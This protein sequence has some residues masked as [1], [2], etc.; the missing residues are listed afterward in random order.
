MDSETCGCNQND[1][2][3]DEK[4]D[5]KLEAMSIYQKRNSSLTSLSLPGSVT[6][7]EW[8]RCK[9]EDSCWLPHTAPTDQGR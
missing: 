4:F 9:K 6:E 7:S 3:P 1:M 2:E 5:E 8:T